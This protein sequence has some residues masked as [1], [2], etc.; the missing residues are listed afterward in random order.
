M[1]TNEQIYNE[2]I[3]IEKEINK[4]SQNIQPQ[5]WQYEGQIWYDRINNIIKVWNWKI[6]E[7]IWQE[8]KTFNVPWFEMEYG[9]NI[10]TINN[11]EKTSFQIKLWT[12]ITHIK[13][14]KFSKYWNAIKIP[15]DWHYL[16]TLPYKIRADWYHLDGSTSKYKWIILF[17]KNL[18]T[19]DIKLKQKSIE[20]NP[21][22]FWLW[23]LY[24][25]TLTYNG[26]FKKDDLISIH[27]N[28]ENYIE[29]KNIKGITILKIK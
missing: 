10:N 2:V 12:T 11:E 6:W 20:I 4:F 29:Y 22:K 17:K 27:S 21:P 25:N 23:F 5:T 16:I 24:P 13:Q 28:S 18:H 14:T 26:S 15:E 19:D 9:V 3:Q 7:K 8:E 1:K